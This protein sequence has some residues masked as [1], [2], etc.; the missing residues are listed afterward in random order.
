MKRT[1]AVDMAVVTLVSLILDM[2]RINCDSPCAFFG[3]FV[4][5]TVIDEFIFPRLLRE[6]LGYGSGERC[7]AVVDVPNGTNI[8]VWFG[9]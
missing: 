7:L 9:S 1:G 2:R 3:R 4:N 5:R 6:N 8:H